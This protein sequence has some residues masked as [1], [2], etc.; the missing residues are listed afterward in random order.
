[1]KKW[2]MVRVKSQELTTR[3]E[4]QAKGNFEDSA[5]LSDTA[6]WRATS[7]RILSWQLRNITSE[8]LGNCIRKIRKPVGRF[9]IIKK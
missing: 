8:F 1:M 6:T 4:V 2:L 3:Y 9:D 7:F 5:E